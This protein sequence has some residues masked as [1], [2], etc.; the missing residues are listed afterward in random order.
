MSE[1]ISRRSFLSVTAKAGMLT[2]LG[3]YV[4]FD[5]PTLLKEKKIAVLG[6]RMNYLTAGKGNTAIVFLHGNPTRAHLWRNIIPYVSSMG[7][8]VAPDLIGMGGSAKLAPEVTDR[9]QFSCHQRFLDAFLH[10]VLKANQQVVLIG[11]D[12]GGVL[13]HDWARRN[14]ERVKGI[15][16]MET[17]L[18]PNITGQT[19]EPVIQWFR[20]FRTE[21]FKNKVLNENHF[22]EQVFLR[23]LPELPEKDREVYR[24]AYQSN[25][26]RL[27]TLIWPREVP[28]DKT[29]ELTHKVF[30]ENIN[31]MSRTTI[32]KLFISADPGALLGHEVRKNVIRQWPEL[33]EVK[34]KG[35]HYIQEQ[36]PDDIGK[37]LQQ[38]L[39]TLK[40]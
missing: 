30:L 10:R 3:P 23:S 19:P 35:N 18:E 5:G 9:Y 24:S 31:F 25:E 22:L 11:H 28:I 26:D 21:E 6:S 40:K 12:W 27:P 36:C 4:F 37:A 32:P 33:T 16:L 1:R 2:A 38:W 15:A 7:F 39:A 29:P 13:S 17:F 8:C 20:N 14:P 34:V